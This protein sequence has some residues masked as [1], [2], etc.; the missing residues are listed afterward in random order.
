[1]D[2][3]MLD[4]AVTFSAISAY[5]AKANEAQNQLDE[6]KEQMRKAAEDLC[7]RWQGDAA[8]AFAQEQGVFNNWCQNMLKIGS[9]YISVLTKAMETY[10]NA[11][12]KVQNLIKSRS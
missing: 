11:E 1:M 12:N 9:E 10:K 8:Q 3:S 6:A 7:S 4:W 2:L 5:L